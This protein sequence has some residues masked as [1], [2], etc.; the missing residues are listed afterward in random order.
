MLILIS[1]SAFASLGAINVGITSSA[2][3]KRI[4]ASTAGVKKYKLIIKK[5]RKKNDKMLLLGKYKLNSINS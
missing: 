1:N 2:M 4:C 3:G 5:K